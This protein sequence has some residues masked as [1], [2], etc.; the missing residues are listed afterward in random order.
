MKKKNW[1]QQFSKKHLYSQKKKKPQHE[2][3]Q[4][5]QIKIIKKLKK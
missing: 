2:I 5:F 1:C 4:N 3:E